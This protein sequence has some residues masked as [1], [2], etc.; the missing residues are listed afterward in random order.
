M[1]KTTCSLKHLHCGLE[2]RTHSRFHLVNKA[3]GAFSSMV[4]S[5]SALFIQERRKHETSRKTDQRRTGGL[6]WGRQTMTTG[7]WLRLFGDPDHPAVKWGRS[8]HW[9]LSPKHRSASDSHYKRRDN[10]WSVEPH[11]PPH[12]HSTLSQ[13]YLIP[14]CWEL[15]ST[16]MRSSQCDP[17]FRPHLPG[18]KRRPTKSLIKDIRKHLQAFPTLLSQHIIGWFNLAKTNISQGSNGNNMINS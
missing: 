2:S 16:W 12:H 18:R 4:L 5:P 9:Y 3:T 10:G 11:F 15:P 17:S 8:G 13:Q 7:P 1:L 14:S 6:R